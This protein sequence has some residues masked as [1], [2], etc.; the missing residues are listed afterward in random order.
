[1]SLQSQHPSLPLPITL[2][3]CID[4]IKGLLV[5]SSFLLEEPWQ[6]IKGRQENE[7]LVVIP[8]VLS[9]QNIQLFR[10]PVPFR[11]G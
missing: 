7:F 3:K 8:L 9:S 6:K 1:M 11:L 2:E 10:T 4:Y 5:Q